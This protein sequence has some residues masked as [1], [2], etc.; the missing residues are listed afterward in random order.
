MSE[1]AGPGTTSTPFIP[2]SH[3]IGSVGKPFRGM[4][5]RL[6][7]VDPKTG[8]GEVSGSFLRADAYSL[9]MCPA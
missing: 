5:I 2:G 6:D 7:H 9:V 8:E 4:E 1:C 3:K